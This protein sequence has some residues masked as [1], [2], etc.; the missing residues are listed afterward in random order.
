MI[1]WP[2]KLRAAAGPNPDPKGD[3]SE[4]DAELISIP[5]VPKV[6]PSFSVGSH[7]L[8]PSKYRDPLHVLLEYITEVRAVGTRLTF[9]LHV[10][11]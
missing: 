6:W 8:N 11:C 5:T 7:C 4:P 3:N 10:W 9:I 1:W 2:K